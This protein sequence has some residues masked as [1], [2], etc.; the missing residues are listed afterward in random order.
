MHE[1]TRHEI[2]LPPQFKLHTVML[3][4]TALMSILSHN[5]IADQA[6]NLGTVTGN[7]NAQSDTSTP[8]MFGTPTN[9]NVEQ[10]SPQQNRNVQLFNPDAS[11]AETEI[12]AGELGALTPS[13][14]FT[15]AL[16]YLPNVVVQTNGDSMTGDNV[17]INGLNKSL[18][19]FTLDGIPLNDN[20]SYTFYTNEFIPVE[21]V[22]GIQYYPSAL[23][24]AIPGLAAFGGSVQTYTK[25]P[26]PDLYA[27]PLI[28]AGSFGKYDY[29]VLFNTGILGANTGAPTSAY[30]YA[31]TTHNDGYFQDTQANQKRVTFKSLTQL[32]QGILT[33][34]YSRNDE[35][36][37]YDKGCT[38]S[39]IDQSGNSCNLLS[40]QPTTPGG[41]PNP[42]YAPYNYN[43]YVDSIGYL[44]FE[45]PLGGGVQLSNQLYVYDGKGYGAGDYSSSTKLLQPNGTYGSVPVPA[46]G[47]LLNQAYNI[48]HRW[49]D[50]LKTL[51]PIGP[52]STEV[53]LWYDH[54]DTTHSNLFFNS[55][56]NAYMGVQYLEPVVTDTSEPYVNVTYKIMPAL[57]LTAGVKYLYVSR[58]FSNQV[59]LVAGNPYQFNSNFKG[60]LPSI[61]LNYKISPL[62][63]VY[64]NYTQNINPPASNQYYIG[65]YNPTLNP[66]QAGTY[67]I[68]STW[69][70][71]SWS[72]SIDAFRLNFSNY[73]LSTNITSGTSTIN[74]LSNAGSA[75]NEGIAWQN[76][77]I[78]DPNWS[79]F[80]N[81]GLL[82]ANFNNLNQ[83]FPYA[84]K[85]TESAGLIFT[86]NALRAQLDAER[87][88]SSYY[89]IGSYNS[90]GT[91]NTLLPLPA[92]TTVNFSVQYMLKYAA[93]NSNIGFK[94]ATISLFV[95]NL[96]NTSYVT[97][98]SGNASNPY[99]YLNLPRNYYVTL[100]ARF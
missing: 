84:P 17:Y 50:T 69:K 44:K 35:N 22:S 83:P 20:N 34:F 25:N 51:I 36:F 92:N 33:L 13:S 11:Q 62:W 70:V 79:A 76:N 77:W 74:E 72:G 46:G 81:L 9:V 71:G 28:G 3:A 100:N 30:I 87:V 63:D 6:I 80:A 64:A 31:D 5:A 90:T 78:L 21:L 12:T 23:S 56:N 60:T 14:S 93:M 47:L 8:Q 53:G 75:T 1:I 82:H 4:I 96:L 97:A 42:Y 99:N 57:S 94:D 18:I 98:Y 41:Q 91:S 15:Q 39:Q 7:A 86:N 2:R 43:N 24:A 59:A 55:T 88:A 58:Q 40:S 66:E 67:D 61:G 54:N 26:G 73:I 45:M 85:N 65:S 95:N 49:G 27:E 48:T 16:A 68:G 29:G 10:V 89:S 37:N 19:N 32:G 38:V 52:T